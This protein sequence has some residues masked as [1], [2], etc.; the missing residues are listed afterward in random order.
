MLEQ[1]RT[2]NFAQSATYAFVLALLASP[3]VVTAV[4]LI[5]L[6]R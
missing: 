2:F 4:I 1:K 3:L 6:A 5:D